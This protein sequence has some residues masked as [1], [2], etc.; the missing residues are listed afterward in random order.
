MQHTKMRILYLREP[1]ALIPTVTKNISIKAN[2]LSIFQKNITLISTI[3][4]NV[5]NMQDFFSWKE[6]KGS[7]NF[8]CFTK[9]RG[10]SSSE[11]ASNMLFVNMIVTVKRSSL[12]RRT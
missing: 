8:L 12:K 1:S 5:T 6:K 9:Q 7:Q 11:I 2:T 3:E 10:T 4:K